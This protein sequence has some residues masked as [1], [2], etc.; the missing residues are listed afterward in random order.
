[1]QLFKKVP[2]DLDYKIR[3][4]TGQVSKNK[5]FEIWLEG[6]ACMAVYSLNVL[7]ISGI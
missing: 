4:H 6:N 7:D 5:D 1:M 3:T 2:L